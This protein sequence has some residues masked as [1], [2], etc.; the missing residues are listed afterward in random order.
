MPRELRSIPV[1]W[2]S[3]LFSLTTD[4]AF[5]STTSNKSNQKKQKF[6]DT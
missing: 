5:R 3:D 1:D 2:E 4:F 6:S